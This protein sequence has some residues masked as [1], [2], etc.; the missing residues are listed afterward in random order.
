MTGDSSAA[1]AAAVSEYW[2]ELVTVPRDGM[3]RVFDALVWPLEWLAYLS[4]E[5]SS[6]VFDPRFRVVVGRRGEDHPLQ[7]VAMAWIRRDAERQFANVR[8]SLMTMT[9]EQFRTHYGI[10]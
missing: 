2:A 8:D 9:P 4:G 1:G 7:G 3:D 6:E 5:P 10:A